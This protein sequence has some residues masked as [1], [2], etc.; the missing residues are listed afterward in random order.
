M[1]YPMSALMT[2]FFNILLHPLDP[3]SKA[4][5]ELLDSASNLIRDMTIRRLTHYEVVHIKLMNDFV[6]ELIR[7]GKCAI[8]KATRERE[9]RRNGLEYRPSHASCDSV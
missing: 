5:V 8:E 7:L 1:F 2:L 4:D 6:M 3:Q 9:Q